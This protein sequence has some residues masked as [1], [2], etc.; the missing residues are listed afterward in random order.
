MRQRQAEQISRYALVNSHF[1][2]AV[3]DVIPG[4]APHVRAGAGTEQHRHSQKNGDDYGQSVPLMLG[5]CGF[6]LLHVLVPDGLG[7]LGIVRVRG[8][9]AVRLLHYRNFASIRVIALAGLLAD[10]GGLHHTGGGWLG[11]GWRCIVMLRVRW[12]HQCRSAFGGRMIVPQRGGGGHR[13]V[14]D[15]GNRLQVAAGCAA[16]QRGLMRQIE[17]VGIQ[18]QRGV[19]NHGGDVVGAAGA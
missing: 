16:H 9:T 12:L 19:R 2:V 8:K 5:T 3:A 1:A 6:L 4:L 13:F 11:A 14:D 18:S 15:I 17:G 7:H 10:G